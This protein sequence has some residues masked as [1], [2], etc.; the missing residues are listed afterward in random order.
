MLQLQ[1]MKCKPRPEDPSFECAKDE[2]IDEFAQGI[3]IMLHAMVEKVDFRIRGSGV[4]PVYKARKFIS[5]YTL[6]NDSLMYKVIPLVQNTIEA[7]D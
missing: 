1:V 2:E 5:S 4:K 6:L 7:Y 3:T